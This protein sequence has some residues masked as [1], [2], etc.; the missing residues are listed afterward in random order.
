MTA[1][2]RVGDT[3]E[4][5]APRGLQSAQKLDRHVWLGLLTP[6]QQERL[7]RERLKAE[8]IHAFY[9]DEHVRRKIGGKLRTVKKPMVSGYVFARFT[10]QP[11]W[12]VIR[13]RAYFSGV[14]SYLGLPYPFPRNDIR[15]LMG[16]RITAEER[17]QA[18]RERQEA[19]EAARAP[20]V[21]EQARIVD[22]PLKG[23]CVDVTKVS[24][25]LVAYVLPNGIPG[26]A[27]IGTIERST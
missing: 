24:G 7:A 17:R 2:Y 18:M 11:N 4:H 19:M 25:R 1:E 26:T 9:P 15:N 14:V 13:G 27:S 23:F 10:H 6:P 3:F 22:G 20:R 16:L 5:V 8:G 21:G 12:D